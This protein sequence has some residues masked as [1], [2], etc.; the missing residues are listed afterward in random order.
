MPPRLHLPAPL[1]AEKIEARQILDATGVQ[2]GLIV[3]LGCGDGKLTAALRATDA[4]LV[5]GLD[6]DARQR[7]GG[8]AARSVARASTA[9]CRSTAGAATR[10]PYI[11]NLVNLLVAERPGW[12]LAG[13]DAAGAGARRRG[14]R[15]DRRAAVDEDRQAA[16][17]GD[18]RVDPLPARRRATTRWPTTRRS[19]RRGTCSGSCGPAWSRHHDHMAS[20]SAMVSAGGRI[21]YIMDEGPREAI[22]L[23]SQWSLIA[24]DAFN[25]TILWKRPIAEWN[26]QLWPLKSGPNQLPRRLVAVGDRVYVTLG[27]DAPLTALDAATGKTLLHLSPAP[28]TP[29]KSSPPTARCSCWSAQAP[30]KWKEYRPK[31]TYVWANTERANKEWAWDQAHRW[32]MAV[33][34]RQRRACCWKQEQRV[35]PLTLAA[36]RAAACSSTTARRSSASI[37]GRAS[38]LWTSAAGAAQAPFPTGYGPTLVVQQDVVL[39]SVEN[40]SM[41][42]SR[43]PTARRSGRPSI[44]PAG[45]C[46]PTTC[47]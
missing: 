25:G 3:H 2:G 24:R 38:E 10:L 4:Y 7:R 23:P 18:R 47:W 17:G 39:L 6:A 45:T 32:L 37:A 20:L 14:L 5:H 28:S 19:A 9:R 33:D 44:T 22:L 1:S 41:T 43:P 40:Q 21:F 27:I 34:G 16:A 30:N 36:D 46:R 15:Q 29:T 26:T 8:P 35:A 12:R 11:D 13:R 42:A 31:F